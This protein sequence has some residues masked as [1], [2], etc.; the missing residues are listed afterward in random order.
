[1]DPG[2]QGTDLGVDTRIVG[3]GTANTPGHDAMQLSVTHQGTAGVT[4]REK[5]RGE[6]EIMNEY[7]NE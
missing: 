2:Q 3:L 5:Q 7:I 1:M 4:L 6:R